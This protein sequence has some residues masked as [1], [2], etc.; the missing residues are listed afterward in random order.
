MQI[1][2]NFKMFVNS[3]GIG[4]SLPTHSQA[5]PQAAL[6]PYERQGEGQAPHPTRVYPE[7]QE[8]SHG[9]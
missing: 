4:L 9:V 7:H 3:K 5:E 1:I 2:D 8:E 6:H